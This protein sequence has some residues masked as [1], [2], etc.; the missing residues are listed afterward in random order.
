MNKSRGKMA[1]RRWL[2]S[3][4]TAKGE[5]GKIDTEAQRPGKSLLVMVSARTS[6]RLLRRRILRWRR[7]S[8]YEIWDGVENRR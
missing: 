3:V 2:S 5:K 7:E 1:K 6:A 8:H 4:K